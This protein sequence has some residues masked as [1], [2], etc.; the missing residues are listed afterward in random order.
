MERVLNQKMVESLK[1][2]EICIYYGMKED[3]GDLEGLNIILKATFPFDVESNGYSQYYKAS[4]R[5][6]KYWNSSSDRPEYPSHPVEDF[7]VVDPI[8]SNY[9]IY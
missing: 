1:K 3:Q 7:F 4:P 2:G 5:D 9:Q 6:Y 8:V